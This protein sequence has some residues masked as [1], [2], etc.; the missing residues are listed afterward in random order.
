MRGNSSNGHQ[1]STWIA[2]FETTTDPDDC[3]VWGWGVCNVDNAEDIEL[4]TDIAS[5]LDWSQAMNATIY[6]HNLKFDG[7][8]IIERLLREGFTH[9]QERTV[10]PGEFSTVISHMGQFYSVTVRWENGNRTEFRDSLKKLPMSVAHVAKAFNLDDS[11]GEIDYHKERPVGYE[12]TEEEKDYIIRDVRIVAQA[13][14]V[15]LRQGMQRLTVGADSLAEYK[16]LITKKQ[17]QRLFPVLPLSMDK[18]IR[19]AYR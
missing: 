16:E 3:R 14:A 15:Q 5:F 18:E 17:F 4:G 7:S 1:H 12:L 19:A 9:T 11:K 6:F 13:I 8:F 2:D 10:R